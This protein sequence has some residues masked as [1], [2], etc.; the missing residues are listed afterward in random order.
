MAPGVEPSG[1]KVTTAP[2][3]GLPLRVTVRVTGAS[4]G[5][6]SPQPTRNHAIAAAVATRLIFIF[7]LPTK[8]REWLGR[9]WSPAAT[10]PATAWSCQ[11]E[12]IGTDNF[13]VADGL[14]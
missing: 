2:S 4:F 3:R 7:G 1:W 9:S 11:S 6:D 13:A 10:R 8:K 12:G 5:P 14:D